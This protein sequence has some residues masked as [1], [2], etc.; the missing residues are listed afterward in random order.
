MAMANTTLLGA[1]DR[2]VLDALFDAEG[3][4]NVTGTDA[5]PLGLHLPDD[6]APHMQALQSQEKDILLSLNSRQPAKEDVLAALAKLDVIIAANPSYASAY[7]NRAQTQRMLVDVSR[8]SSPSDFNELK[9]ILD[10]LA[11]AIQLCTPTVVAKPVSV[12]DA[13]VLTSAH[14]HRGYLLLVIAQS[15][16]M[17]ALV[18]ANPGLF[19]GLD[20]DRLEEMAS[21]EL[22]LGGKFGNNAA[23]QL[24]V[25]VNP[26]AKLCGEIV[27]EALRKE[28]D[29]GA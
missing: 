12:F 28:M 23:R 27:R 20:K 6:P 18:T 16:Q 15:E 11:M 24:A 19:G 5:G 25:K 3:A 21:H 29:S 2:A 4:F 9:L 14:S 10:D 1:N 7:N 13:K 26:Y 8:L 17:A 22:A